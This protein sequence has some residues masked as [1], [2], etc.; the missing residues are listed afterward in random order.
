[1]PILEPPPRHPEGTIEEFTTPS[2]GSA[3]RLESTR[4]VQGDFPYD[5][6]LPSSGSAASRVRDQISWYSQRAVRTSRA[7][8]AAQ[9]VE[10]LVASAIPVFLT[11]Y[12]TGFVTVPPVAISLLASLIV[13]S[14]GVQY[15]FFNP[16]ESVRNRVIAERLSRELN[17]YL[18]R[19]GPYDQKDETR[20]DKVLTARAV[21][22]SSAVTGAQEQSAEKSSGGSGPRPWARAFIR[23]PARLWG[24]QLL[25]LAI[26]AGLSLCAGLPVRSSA[27]FQVLTV[28]SGILLF[29]VLVKIVTY[30]PGWTPTP[31]GRP[32]W[33]PLPRV[34]APR[35]AAAVQVSDVV[36]T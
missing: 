29:V 28:L 17:L 23:T 30:T 35:A 6:L 24:V 13:L 12:V 9:L 33:V 22:V 18:S 8:R 20:D 11:A 26:A 3:F 19:S 1:M 16:E 27:L 36:E 25:E 7:L 32:P 14:V 10:L 5:G 15:I 4:N 34:A 2:V 31:E 21:E